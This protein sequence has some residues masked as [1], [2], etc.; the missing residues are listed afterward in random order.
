[1]AQKD[2]LQV[3][4][5]EGQAGDSERRGKHQTCL[6]RFQDHGFAEPLSFVKQTRLGCIGY[7]PRFDSPRRQAG[8]AR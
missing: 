3:L 6:S 8:G 2:G 5:G 4:R 1:M 7:T